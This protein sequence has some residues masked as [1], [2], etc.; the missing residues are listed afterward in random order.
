MTISKQNRK[1]WPEY[2]AALNVPADCDANLRRLSNLGTFR[3][4]VSKYLENHPALHKDMTLLVRQLQPQPEGMP[5][6]IY[7]F[8]RTTN[9]DEYEAIQGDIFDHLLAILNEF[10]LRAYQ[11][12][13][14]ADLASRVAEAP[15]S[16]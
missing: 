12:P 2:N 10:G 11:R 7:C 13:G 6:E 1:S 15:E 9:W 8:T 3:A 14:G 4:Y 16:V 5:I